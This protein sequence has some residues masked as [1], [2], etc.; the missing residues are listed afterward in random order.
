MPRL[1]FTA[2]L[3]SILGFPLF[4]LIRQNLSLQAFWQI[5]TDPQPFGDED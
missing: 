4:V 1:L 5:W 2:L 3:G